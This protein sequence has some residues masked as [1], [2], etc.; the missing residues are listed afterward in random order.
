MINKVGINQVFFLCFA[1]MLA[2]NSPTSI[3]TDLSCPNPSGQTN[4]GNP[5]QFGPYDYRDSAA[6]TGLSS[7]LQMVESRHFNTDVATLTHGL[8][9]T[10]AGDLSYTLRVFPN[11]HR[12]LQSLA[13]LGLR[14][15]KMNI[16]D[17]PFTI[18]C[19]FIRAKNYAPT[20]GMVNAVYAYYLANLNQKDLALTEAEQA[21][22]KAGNNSRIYYDVGLAYY[23]MGNYNKAQEYS[24][25]AKK[26][27]ST[28]VGLDILLSKV[29][30]KGNIKH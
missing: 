10:I 23:Y 17:L 28:A 9:S 8:S 11:H 26:L 18:P 24:N 27:G 6:K 29:F 12:A 16:Q 20:D 30:P 15:K 7:P 3:A 14:D 19:F 21:I 13:D 5:N 22:K 25:T 1:V 2:L 4:G